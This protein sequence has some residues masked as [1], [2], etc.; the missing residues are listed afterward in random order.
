MK[1]IKASER[2]PKKYANYHVKCKGKLL[3]IYDT[4]VIFGAGKWYYECKQG[5]PVIEW[6][7]E[8]EQPDPPSGQ[9]IWS[10]DDVRKLVGNWTAELL[11]TH[12]K[13]NLY[14]KL[15]LTELGNQFKIYLGTYPKPESPL[16][17]EPSFSSMMWEK[18]AMEG[19]E[20]IKELQSCLGELVEL[21]A[22][23]AYAGPENPIW[24]IITR[25]K[26]L[27]NP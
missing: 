5:D 27:L 16:T 6:L 11:L 9:G 13:D 19:R 15:N 21:S 17:P 10:N 23:T 2:Q 1:W 4:T 18:E 12:L 8:S 7:D 14:G 22:L 3:N 26:S 20:L 25:A 24:G